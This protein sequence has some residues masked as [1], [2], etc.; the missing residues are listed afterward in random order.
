MKNIYFTVG[1]SQLYPTYHKHMQQA[2]KEDIGSI[3]HRGQL[4][5]EIYKNADSQL[6]KLMNIPLTHHIFF[7]GSALEAM[8]RTV[9]NLVELSSY[10]LI[11]GEFSKKFFEFS[12]Q[13]GKKPQKI[14]VKPGQGFDFKKIKIPKDVELICLTQNETSTGTMIKM[15]QIYSLKKKNP[16]ALIAMDIVSSVPYVDIDFSKIDSAFFSVQKGFG[17]PAGLGVLIVSNKAVKKAQQ[18]HKKNVSIGTYHNFL[19]LVEKETIFQTPETPNV[20]NIY[21]LGQIC[22]DMNKIGIKKIR[23]QIDE[24]AKLIYDFFDNHKSLKPFISDLDFRSTTTMTIETNGLSKKIITQLASKGFIVSE[25]YGQFKDTQIRIANFPTHQ[26]AD[27]K[28][29]LVVLASIR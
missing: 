3:S 11:N 4:F 12:V 21:L 28:R 6:R 19:S 2:L 25:G 22:Q 24:K 15:D 17:L 16:Q 8:E 20:L 13:L 27:L 14:E 7:T 9:Q 18:L 29:M 10:H 5:K 26:M 23:Q 1:P